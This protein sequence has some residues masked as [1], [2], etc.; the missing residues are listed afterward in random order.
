M[1]RLMVSI[2]PLIVVAS[3]AAPEPL[4]VVSTSPTLYQCMQDVVELYC[5]QQYV[6]GDLISA[7]EVPICVDIYI[8]YVCALRGCGQECP[9]SEDQIDRCLSAFSFSRE[10]C[11]LPSECIGIW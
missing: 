5:A 2:L 9:A 7:E 11:S 8:S 1:S 3:C 4:E 6:C 10:Q